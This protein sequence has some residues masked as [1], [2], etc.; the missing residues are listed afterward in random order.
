MILQLPRRRPPGTPRYTGWRNMLLEVSWPW[1]LECV[2][3]GHL[4]ATN[5]KTGQPRCIWCRR[6]WEVGK[7]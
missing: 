5:W 1:F 3:S 4:M 6:Q 2:L 7:C